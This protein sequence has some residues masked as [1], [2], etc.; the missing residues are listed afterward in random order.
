MIHSK[1]QEEQIGRFGRVFTLFIDEGVILRLKLCKFFS[2]K[3]IYFGHVLSPRRRKIAFNKTDAIHRLKRQISF[4]KLR[5]FL[6]VRTVFRCFIPNLTRKL[7]ALNEKLWKSQPFVIKTLSKMQI[8]SLTTL[9]N[10]LISHTV[11]ALSKS[12][13]PMTPDVDT[14]DAQIG[15]VP[16]QQQPD[17]LSK[18][19]GYWS[20]SLTD[21]K[22]TYDTPQNKY[23]EIVRSVLSL[24]VY[25]ERIRFIICTENDS[26]KTDP[27]LYW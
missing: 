26:L 23:F 1:S 13:S 5:S 9:I 2:E 6:G 18:P 14:C 4:R 21:T 12:T 10:A 3:I 25:L 8:T 11:L 20:R 27:Q 22:N 16:S 19:I 15:C 7:A 17:E 24:C